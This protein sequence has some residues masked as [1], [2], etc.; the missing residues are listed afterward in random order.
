[1]APPLSDVRQ[2]LSLYLG[3]TRRRLVAQASARGLGVL[4]IRGRV[5]ERLLVAPTDL[6]TA[7]PYIADEVYAGRF[8]LAGRV[9]ETGGASPFTSAPPSEDFARQLH[10][11]RWLRHLRAAN[12]ELAFANARALTDDWIQSTGRRISGVPWDPDIVAQRVIAWMSHSPVVLK[13]SDHGF[14]RR[15]LKSLAGQLAFLRR[16]AATAA[17]GEPRFRVRIALAMGTLALPASQ[18]AIRAAARHLDVEIDRQILPDGGH[19]SRNPQAGLDLLVDLLPLRQTYVNLGHGSPA[20][21][22]PAIDRMFPALRFFRHGDGEL[23]LFNGATAAPVE[24]L[25]SVL[26]YDET[27]G[28]PFR[29]LPHSKFQRLSAGT[30]TILADTGAPPRGAPSARAH[31]GC[32]S[33]EMSSGHHRIIVNAGA[34]LFARDDHAQ[35]AR[36][37]AAHSTVTVENTSSSR[38]S[39]SRFLGPVLAGGV[40]TV[41]VSMADTEDGS[42]SFTASHDGYVSLYSLVHER[43][44]RLSGDGARVEGRD[45]F[46]RPDGAAAGRNA[47]Q[48]AVARFHIHPKTLIARGSDNDLFLTTPQGE[49]W[50][51]SCREVVPEIQDDVFFA[52]VAGPRRSRQ[53]ALSSRVG[54]IPELHW[55]LVRR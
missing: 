29:H 13:G 4:R 42:R 40:G 39:L 34:P 41:T 32:L 21:L 5:P 12:H 20:R 37:T 9:L 23:A 2:S 53:I 16:V 47:R 3:E 45:R 26:R 25:L 50:T 30:T 44:I 33:F 22:I 46:L 43:R 7:D 11:F 38:T 36:S 19:V 17:E 6:R 8:S 54:T 51:F 27:S 55:M 1:M 14:Y 15:F 49:L 52:D 48:S 24:R 18:G 35:L 31:A 10:A 28:T